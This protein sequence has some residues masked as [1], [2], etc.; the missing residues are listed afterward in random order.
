MQFKSRKIIHKWTQSGSQP[1]CRCSLGWRRRA[2]L[3][4]AA[5]LPLVPLDLAAESLRISQL[6]S[7]ALL[8]TQQLELHLALSDPQGRPVSGVQIAEL[9]VFESADNRHFVP[10]PIS[11]FAAV[12]PESLELQFLILIDNSGSMY[13]HFGSGHGADRRIDGALQAT[14]QLVEIIANGQNQVALA[15]YNT[16]YQL[17]NN[18]TA[19]REQI[20]EQLQAVKR[21]EGMMMHTELYASLYQAVDQIRTRKG[22]RVLIVLSDGENRP[23]VQHGGGLHPDYGVRIW[24]SREALEYSQAEGIAVNVI[25]YGSGRL[26]KDRELQHIAHQ[27]GGMVFDA[28]STDQLRQVYSQIVE[29]VK[30]EYRLRYRAS[31][32]PATR[33]FV[34]VIYKKAGK[35]SVGAQRYY[36]A[37][38]LPGLPANW[39]AI[40]LLLPLLL[41]L[42]GFWLLSRIRTVQESHSAE[43]EVLDGLASGQSKSLQGMERTVI[44]ASSATG[45][46]ITA[47]GR[48]ATP[49]EAT[50]LYNHKNK[51]HTLLAGSHT[52]VNNRPVRSKV[53]QSGDVIEVAGR[54]I[55]FDDGRI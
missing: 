54:R 49:A 39:P 33:R 47:Q 5:M 40:W 8:P 26:Q 55:V 16:R 43:L 34:K 51:R 53:L 15:A 25:N 27:T 32:L 36:F 50:I 24:Q 41:A 19:D 38:S 21:P 35:S 20:L 29:Q 46:Q 10:R 17:L 37:S 3:C 48:A 45:L 9:Q 14:R 42:A 6:D 31:M 44:N 1:K 2:G 22:R 30:G 28:R 13:N 11:H 18:F 52:L 4:L 23:M 12:Q 7:L